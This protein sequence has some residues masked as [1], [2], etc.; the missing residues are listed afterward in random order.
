MRRSDV[1]GFVLREFIP[2]LAEIP[3]EVL[4]LEITFTHFAQLL[5]GTKFLHRFAIFSTL[6]IGPWQT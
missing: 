6:Q 1:F 2:I 5:R 3:H 4:V